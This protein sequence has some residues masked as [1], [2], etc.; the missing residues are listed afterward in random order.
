MLEKHGHGGDIWTAAELYGIDKN[1][2]LDFSSNMNPL[3]PP[4]AAE[5]IIRE[6]W[7]RELSR[8][9]DPDCRELRQK[10]ASVYSIPA[11]SVLAG[12]GAAEIIDLA[13]RAQRPRTVG[14]LAPS[15]REYATAAQR[16]GAGIVDIPLSAERNFD[17]DWTSAEL[18]KAVPEAELFLFGHPNNPTGRL[19]STEFV[20]QLAATGKPVILDE[21]F[22]D[23]SGEEESVSFIRQAA[24]SDRLCV[25]R[26]LT[27]FYTVPGLRLGFA[28]AG[29]GWIGAMKRLQVEWSVNGLAQRIGQEVLGDGEFARATRDWLREESAW[30]T[31]ALTGLGLQVTPSAANYLLFRLPGEWG[32]TIHRLQEAMGRRGILIRSA[33]TYQGLDERYGRIAVRSRRDNMRLATELAGCLEELRA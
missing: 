8:Y 12:N 11:S 24:E 27:K 1:S 22:I 3:G 29:Q 33:A 18:Q 16:A 15:F 23:F 6:E 31:K 26:S 25:V 7:R 17:P 4:E 13:V 19:L 9:P 20:R 21:A 14:L 30:L 28:V 10:I 32:V 5:R 2:F